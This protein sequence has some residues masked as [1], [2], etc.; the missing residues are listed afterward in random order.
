MVKIIDDL[1]IEVKQSRELDSHKITLT[2]LL[3]Y[4]K[5]KD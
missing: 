1:N 2:M 3:R 5:F 4:N